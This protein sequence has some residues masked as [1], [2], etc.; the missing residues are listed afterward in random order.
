MS[1]ITEIPGFFKKHPKTWAYRLTPKAIR[2]ELYSRP[3]RPKERQRYW[4]RI[5]ELKANLDKYA[6]SYI[7]TDLKNNLEGESDFEKL[8]FLTKNVTKERTKKSGLTWPV[9]NRQEIIDSEDT[10]FRRADTIKFE[11]V[12]ITNPDEEK[13]DF[14]LQ[15]SSGTIEHVFR[16]RNTDEPHYVLDPEENVVQ[17]ISITFVLDGGFKVTGVSRRDGIPFPYNDPDNNIYYG[18]F[19][20]YR[21]LKPQSKDS[22]HSGI[23]IQFDTLEQAINL[24]QESTLPISNSNLDRKEG[25]V[26]L[27][28]R[29]LASEFGQMQ[30]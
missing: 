18:N 12:V 8:I 6:S 1:N 25:A 15:F 28:N 24:A 5:E 17:S 22:F 7:K 14:Q 19:A 9:L 3:D 13:N 27:V 23:P 29:A 20:H 4:K 16:D 30:L 10:E 11:H 21:D 26:Y 2:K